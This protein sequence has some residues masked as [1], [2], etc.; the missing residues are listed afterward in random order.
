MTAEQLIV[1][2]GSLTTLMLGVVRVLVEVR[3]THRAVNSRMDELVTLTR[4]AAFARGQLAG[5]EPPA[6]HSAPPSQR[7]P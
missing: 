4:A 1:V 5:P 7:G 3:R 2:I 6:G